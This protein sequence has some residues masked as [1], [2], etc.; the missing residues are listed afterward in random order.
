MARRFG[1]KLVAKRVTAIAK[2]GK[3]SDGNG[4]YL[5]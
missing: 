2:P 5:R 4:L 3:H 1:N